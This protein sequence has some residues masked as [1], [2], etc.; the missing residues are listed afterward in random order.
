MCEPGC[1]H[2]AKLGQLVWIPLGHT[3]ISY[4]PNPELSAAIADLI[5]TRDTSSN[6]P[7]KTP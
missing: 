4:P 3:H 6:Q 2:T 1:D 7:P 5:R